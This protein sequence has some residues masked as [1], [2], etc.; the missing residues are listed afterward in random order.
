MLTKCPVWLRHSVRSLARGLLRH[1]ELTRRV[2]A[3]AFVCAE[4]AAAEPPPRRGATR[5]AASTRKRKSRG[6]R[7]SDEDSSSA[8]E[9]SSDSDSDE[10]AGRRVVVPGARSGTRS[11]TRA[12]GGAASGAGA[13]EDVAAAGP[14]VA[15]LR[16]AA[17]R[18]AKAIIAQRRRAAE[19]HA[20][21]EALLALSALEHGIPVIADASYY[22][23]TEAYTAFLTA[24]SEPLAPSAAPQA[25]SAAAVAAAAISAQFAARA[26]AIDVALEAGLSAL[27]AQWNMPR[28]RMAKLLGCYS[29]T[30][31]DSSKLKI[32]SCKYRQSF[33]LNGVVK[34]KLRF[35][36]SS[37][38]VDAELDMDEAVERMLH[39]LRLKLRKG[40]AAPAFV[41]DCRNELT[42]S[43]QR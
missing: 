2:P 41:C 37:R 24:I 42:C 21:L 15:D 25:Q 28:A 32:N 31:V 1:L 13:A 18:A 9:S 39:H 14:L 43:A 29:E 23:E 5:T 20:E 34:E 36:H 27:V 40:G 16:E 3:A 22:K 10:F 35:R 30:T 12:G 11:S 7:S 26:A 8:A 19:V 17:R 6:W 38:V 33:I 4:D